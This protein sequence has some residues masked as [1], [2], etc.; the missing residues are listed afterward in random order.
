MEIG[1]AVVP[2][3]SILHGGELTLG[4]TATIAME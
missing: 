3:S 2:D 1:A 4:C